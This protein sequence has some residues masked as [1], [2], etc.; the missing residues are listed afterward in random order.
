MTALG[1]FMLVVCSLQIAGAIV[2]SRKNRS[3][4]ALQIAVAVWGLLGLV[5]GAF[6][7]VFPHL[8]SPGAL[9]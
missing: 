9:Y 5:V 2:W 8:T 3:L 4:R 1:A 6:F 7:V